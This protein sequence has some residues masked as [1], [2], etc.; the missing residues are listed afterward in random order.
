MLCFYWDP[1]E[2]HVF[3]VLFGI[4]ND[5][6][7]IIDLDKLLHLNFEGNVA[8]CISA[9]FGRA[10]PM[11]QSVKKNV[12]SRSQSQKAASATG[13]FEL[14]L[15][16]CYL[17]WTSATNFPFCRILLASVWDRDCLHVF[18]V[19]FQIFSFSSVHPRSFTC[20]LSHYIY[21]YVYIIRLSDYQSEITK[22]HWFLHLPSGNFLRSYWRHGPFWNRWL[23]HE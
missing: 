23:T 3:G 19:D 6:Y 10:L 16:G 20:F 9:F 22:S 12:R 11:R 4:H 18:A 8:S 7:I 21:I 14:K 5:T 2:C 17:G 15:S 13:R 1:K